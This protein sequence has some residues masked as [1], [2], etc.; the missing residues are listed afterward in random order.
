M[1]V[2]KGLRGGL[3]ILRERRWLPMYLTFGDFCSLALIFIGIIGLVLS[4]INHKR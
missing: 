4:G 1:L 2:L 3:T